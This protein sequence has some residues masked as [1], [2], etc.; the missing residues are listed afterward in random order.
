MR[1][2][3]ANELVRDVDAGVSAAERHLLCTRGIVD[4]ELQ[5]AF[6][7]GIVHQFEDFGDQR[8]VDLLE[9]GI[10]GDALD[11]SVLDVGQPLHFLDG[12][13][14]ITLSPAGGLDPGGDENGV[15]HG[16]IAFELCPGVAEDEKSSMR[17]LPKA[18]PLLEM[19][20]SAAVTIP[21]KV[22][23]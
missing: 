9:S 3:V 16:K 2:D 18:L 15:A 21:P 1:I 8:H 6:S 4:V 20:S 11:L 5:C 13:V 23:S 12:Q 10:D 14:G 22:I 17:I 7:D 19:R